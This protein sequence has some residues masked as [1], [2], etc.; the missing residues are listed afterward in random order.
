MSFQKR[1]LEVLSSEE[2]KNKELFAEFTTQCNN[3]ADFDAFMPTYK[4]TLNEALEFFESRYEDY[5]IDLL[6]A[7]YYVF[8]AKNPY[9]F[10]GNIDFDFNRYYED[11]SKCMPDQLQDLVEAKYLKQQKQRTAK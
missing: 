10:F 11:M 7:V 2:S 8:L 6:L 9:E 3:S 4:K 1:T 5:N